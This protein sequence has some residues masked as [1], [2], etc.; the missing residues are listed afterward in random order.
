MVNPRGS[1]G[2]E[3]ILVEAGTRATAEVG[4]ITARMAMKNLKRLFRV[5]IERS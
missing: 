4:T 1:E 2:Y 3:A 5:L